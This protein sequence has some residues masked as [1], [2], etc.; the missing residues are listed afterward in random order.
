MSY[1]H[2]KQPAFCIY[3]A[4]HLPEVT[5]SSLFLSSSLW[6][7]K[8]VDIFRYLDILLRSGWYALLRA[9]PQ[10][11]LTNRQDPRSDWRNCAVWRSEHWRLDLVAPSGETIHICKLSELSLESF[12]SPTTMDHGPQQWA[13]HSQS[14][15]FIKKSQC[16]KLEKPRHSIS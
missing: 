2:L 12:V 8:A 11:L 4:N 16:K 6:A 13:K 9:K 14:F 5:V 1:I 3:S 7:P 15:Y 10:R